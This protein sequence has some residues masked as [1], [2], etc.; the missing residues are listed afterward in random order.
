MLLIARSASDVPEILERDNS[1]Y[2]VS[3]VASKEESDSLLDDW[4]NMETNFGNLGD[5]SV[6]QSKLP[7]KLKKRRWLYRDLIFTRSMRDCSSHLRVG[8]MGY[9]LLEN[10]LYRWITLCILTPKTVSF[11]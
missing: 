4:L 10:R 11:T 5:L 2:K 1:Y 6:V 3:T 8:T 9:C 7:K